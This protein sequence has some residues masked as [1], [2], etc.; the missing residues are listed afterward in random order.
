[1]IPRGRGQII[2]IASVQSEL[3]RTNIAPYTASKGAAK[4]LTKG[5]ATDWGKHGLRANALAPGYFRTE[6]NKALIEDE[7][8]SAWLSAR[9][10]LGRLVG[11][12]GAGRRGDL[13]CL[14]RVE[15]RQRACALRRRR[16]DGVPLIERLEFLSTGP[17]ADDDQFATVQ[18]GSRRLQGCDYRNRLV[19]PRGH[20]LVDVLWLVERVPGGRQEATRGDT[21][22]AATSDVGRHQPHLMPMSGE[23][24]A[25]MV[26]AAARLHPHN[27][28]RQLRRQRDHRLALGAPQ[29]DCAGRIEPNQA[30]NVLAKID[31][32]YSNPHDPLLSEQ[33]TSLRRRREGR[34]IP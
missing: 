32:Q 3:A 34:A 12:A 25:E 28:R 16:R 7:K 21:A 27:A 20:R 6:L 31:A 5:M 23:Y 22:R 8:F 29:D 15:L 17:T 30:A 33:P 9:T 18:I 14:E 11:R 13:S 2:N 19:S 26:G 10:P 24:A 1:M 4:M